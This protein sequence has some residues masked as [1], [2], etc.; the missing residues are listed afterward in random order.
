[1]NPSLCIPRINIDIK[2]NMIVERFKQLNI[3]KI[4]NVDIIFKNNEKNQKF[5]S[6]FIHIQ[7]NN[8]ELSKYI[9]NRIVSGKDI[10]VI[11]DGFLFWK[12]FMNK[13]TKPKFRKD[14][15]DLWERN[16]KI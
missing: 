15:P 8:S 7:W 14:S 10:K 16:S 5:Y 11:Y 2:K 13:S 1:M 12:V 4:E 6:V 3:G 9:I